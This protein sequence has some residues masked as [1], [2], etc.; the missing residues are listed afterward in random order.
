MKVS[1][2]EDSLHNHGLRAVTKVSDPYAD[3]YIAETDLEKPD[4]EFPWGFY[5]TA[6]FLVTNK[7][8]GNIDIGRPLYFDAMHDRE[9]GWTQ[10]QKRQMRIGATI[11]DARGFVRLC[12]ESG[13]LNG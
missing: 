11:E 12:L 1:Q 4:K 9:K 8:H 3:I 7:S 6:W 10:E 2:L 5:Q 13:R